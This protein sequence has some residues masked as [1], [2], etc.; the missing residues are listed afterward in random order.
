MANAAACR[1][2]TGPNAKREKFT[3][4]SPSES[5]NTGG[6]MRILVMGMQQPI[7]TRWWQAIEA[8]G[9]GV[10]DLRPELETVHYSPQWKQRLGFPD[11][12]EADSTHFWRCRVHPDDLEG[13]LAA[14]RAHM[15]APDARP[16]YEATF[17]LRSNGSGYRLVRSRGRA[18]ERGAEGQV[19]RMVGT[20]VDLTGRPSTPQG[21]LVDSTQGPMKRMPLALPFH[22]LLEV[23][24]PGNV[25]ASTTRRPEQ[26]RV[27]A[28]IEDLLH[29][30]VAQLDGPHAS[31]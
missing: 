24:R 19:L 29:A 23:E 17:R 27:F 25:I 3:R 31:V 9:L 5:R 8:G 13:M 26:A 28:M 18:I 15:L 12:Y 10:W 20:M 1:F 4:I 6:C 2:R 21:G 14:M 7:E 30:A 22:L 11:P 16:D